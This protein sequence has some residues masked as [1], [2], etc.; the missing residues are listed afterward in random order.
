MRFIVDPRAANSMDVDDNGMD[1]DNEEDP[2]EED[3]PE[4]EV[5]ELLDDMEN[6]DIVDDVAQTE[7][8]EE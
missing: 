4:I 8:E 7:A 1:M 2:E 6:L 3:F 5:D